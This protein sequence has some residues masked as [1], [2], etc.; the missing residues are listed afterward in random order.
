MQKIPARFEFCR[1][2]ECKWPAHATVVFGTHFNLTTS[3]PFFSKEAAR[4]FLQVATRSK[5]IDGDEAGGLDHEIAK[6][7]LPNDKTCDDRL[8][9]KVPAHLAQFLI[10]VRYGVNPI[11]DG[12]GEA[13]IE[14]CQGECGHRYCG[15]YPAHA[16]MYVKGL[17][18]PTYPMFSNER[19]I[20][21]ILALAEKG[22]LTPSEE[23]RLTKSLGGFNL[24][25][26]TTRAD[27]MVKAGSPFLNEIMAFVLGIK[28]P[29]KDTRPVEFTICD[30]A[31]P[32]GHPDRHGHVSIYG[33]RCGDAL[34][35]STE[36]SDF[37]AG[38][39]EDGFIELADATRVLGEIE[40]A[41]LSNISSDE[42]MWNV[43]SEFLKSFLPPRP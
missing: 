10:D 32:E 6:S 21:L 18:D 17:S 3:L 4:A 5:V 39:M 33:F 34:R 36:A 37:I 9:E 8:F 43:F 31:V 38:L 25:G 26:D 24:E 28:E 42:Q 11:P 27:K 23:K 2:A 20:D 29:F 15:Q 12:T 16:L 7:A 30:D 13:R 14:A 1:V 22:L 41:H 19:A 35:S 40:A